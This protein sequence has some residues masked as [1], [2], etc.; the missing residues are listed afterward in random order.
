MR[1]VLNN[2]VFERHWNHF[3]YPYILISFIILFNIGEFL[4]MA[5]DWLHD[6]NYSHGFLVIPVSIYLIWRKGNE[7]FL[8]ARPSRWGAMLFGIGS[9]VFLLGIASSEF[10]TT[11]VSL[12]MMISGISLYYLGNGNFK[13]IWFSFAF[14]IFMVPIPAVIY[15]TATVPMQLFASKVSSAILLIPG[16]PLVRDGNIIHLP[17]YSLEVVEACSGLRSLVSLLALSALYGY[18]TLSGKVRPLILFLAAIP[19]A[20][21][22]NILRLVLSALAAYTISAEF[23]E[24]FLHGIAGIMVFAAAF[25]FIVITG[26][27]LKWSKKRS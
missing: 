25:I 13:R 3:K 12:L 2:R 21:A 24:G 4:H 16:V 22:M 15:H 8:P 9:V 17:G 27:V 7:I 18:L 26:S 1:L 6:S 10:F 19:I 11:R 20:I 14:L 23:A 5:K